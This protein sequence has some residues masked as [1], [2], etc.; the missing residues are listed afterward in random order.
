VHDIDKEAVKEA[1]TEIKKAEDYLKGVEK[2]KEDY[3]KE[4]D[5]A[6]EDS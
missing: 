2:S 1:K 6:E 4:A 5:V 3:Q